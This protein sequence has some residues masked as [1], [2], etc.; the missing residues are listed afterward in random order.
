MAGESKL[1]SRARVYSQVGPYLGL[2]VEL[3]APVLFCMAVGWWLDK[4][5]ETSPM[6]MLVGAFVG[7]GVGFYSFFRTVLGLQGNKPEAE[8]DEQTPEE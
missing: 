1:S 2:G 6:L 8:G 4:R 5:F 7:A 3:V